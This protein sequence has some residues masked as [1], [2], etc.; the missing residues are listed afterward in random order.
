MTRRRD[1]ELSG[2]KPAGRAPRKVGLDRRAV[3]SVSAYKDSRARPILRA[4][5]EFFF[6]VG[7][8]SARSDRAVESVGREGEILTKS[9]DSFNLYAQEL[10]DTTRL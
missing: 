10:A 8:L 4:P 3:E 1:A 7:R 5:A 2:G 9:A 6:K